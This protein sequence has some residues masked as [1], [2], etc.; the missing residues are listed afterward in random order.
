MSIKT[1][2]VVLRDEAEAQRV[3][4]V[5]AQ[6]AQSDNAHILACH[7]EFSP[8]AYSTSV[9]FIDAKT[10]Q[11]G[12]DAAEKRNTALHALVD[13]FASRQGLSI[14]WKSGITASGDSGLA[15]LSSALAADLI[16]AGQTDPSSQSQEWV[17]LEAL[18]MES[19]RPVLLVPYVGVPE[20]KLSRCVVAWDG[21]REAARATFDALPFLKAAA[22]VDLVLVDAQA[23]SAQDPAVAGADI[24]ETLARHG[25]AVT[26]HN[27]V[28]GNL[29][30]GTVINNFLADNGAD[31]LVMGAYSH[32]RM[33][34]M[35]FGGV[36]KTMLASMTTLTFMSR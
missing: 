34:Q 17:D 31:L 1:L 2:L 16:V 28:S 4:P 19:G 9:G 5:A 25:V 24:A 32:S 22:K 23:S 14:A 29:S 12:M 30:A 7:A 6:L 11:D 36:T 33:R 18:L 15:A 21:K 8:I 13:D 10:I 35:I 3:L 26:V 20:P 27:L